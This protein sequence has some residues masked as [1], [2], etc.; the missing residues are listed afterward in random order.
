M[1]AI[2]PGPSTT[3]VTNCPKCKDTLRIQGS[4]LHFQEVES[5]QKK[6]GLEIRHSATWSGTCPNWQ[7]LINMQ[8]DI[9][10]YPADLINDTEVTFQGYPP[11]KKRDLT[12]FMHAPLYD[13]TGKNIIGTFTIEAEGNFKTCCTECNRIHKVNSKKL[14]YTYSE[15][16][17][18]QRASGTIFHKTSWEKLCKCGT[19]LGISQTVYSELVGIIYDSAS[20]GK[21]CEVL[22]GP[23]LTVV[24]HTQ[25]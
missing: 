11:T 16:E 18:V 15:N 25:E 19:K 10:E 13:E 5:R 4:E 8:L 14:I 3:F 24:K 21:N 2:L 7:E 12:K 17:D 23:R 20:H 22:S 9:W 1:S 6:K